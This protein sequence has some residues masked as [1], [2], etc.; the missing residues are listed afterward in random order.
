MGPN[1]VDGIGCP[2]RGQC[3]VGLEVE[4]EWIEI[5]GGGGNRLGGKVC[6]VT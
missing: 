1:P 4:R 5:G 2:S 6:A 3:A